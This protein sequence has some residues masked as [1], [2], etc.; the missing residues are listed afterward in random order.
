MTIIPIRG[1][2]QLGAL[3]DV[4]PYTVPLQGV[5]RCR[6]VKFKDGVVKSFDAF[7]TLKTGGSLSNIPI[8]AFTR[9]SQG[10]TANICTLRDDG[11]IFELVAG[12]HVD[13]SGTSGIG[14]VTSTPTYTM[15]GDVEYLT[16][17][18]CIP[19]SR[20]RIATTFTKIPGWA[21]LDRCK[22]MRSYKDFLIAL[23]ITKN[24]T[25]YPNMIKWSDATQVGSPPANWD[26]VSPS[27]LA[28]EN[29]L[30]DA[31]GR[32]IDG[33]TLGP[34]F[35]LYGSNETYRMD[36]VGQ[37]FIFTTEKLFG[38]SGIISQNCVASV[39]QAHYVFTSNDIIRHDGLQKVSIADGRVRKRIF[40]NIVVEALT[41]CFVF[42]DVATSRIIFGY[43]SKSDECAYPMSLLGGCNE[44][45][46]YDVLADTWTFID[47]PNVTG[48]SQAS[49]PSD[50]SWDDLVTWNDVSGNWKSLEGTALPLPL[51]ASADPDQLLFLDDLRDGYLSTPEYSGAQYPGFVE[52][53]HRDFDEL[54]IPITADKTVRSLHPQISVDEEGAVMTIGVGSSRNPKDPPTYDL[55][56][57]FYPLTQ[58]RHDQ[59]VSGKYL[60]V[61]FGFPT[62]TYAE[63]SGYDLDVTSLS[64]R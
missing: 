32:L 19:V 9:L 10:G 25:E 3:P 36:Y 16:T 40:T 41:R 60:A 52:F 39:D 14:V 21:T 30:N 47:L 12:T 46:V 37:P 26:V 6:N 59:M 29:I 54:Q 51:T 31:T 8:S 28:G 17:A 64:R 15:L 44:A 45:A 24:V 33:M 7:K 43:P 53:T 35:I 58:S 18:N 38:S 50:S 4:P 1:L 27:S 56:K 57:P 2:A 20:S 55:K 49:L 42:Y 11:T 34:S 63:L 23:N 5:T 48:M 22:S 13:V 62:V 61:Y